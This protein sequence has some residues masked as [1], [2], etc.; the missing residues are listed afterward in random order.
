MYTRPLLFLFSPHSCKSIA[1]AKKRL[2]MKLLRRHEKTGL[3]KVN[4]DP[5]LVRRVG[6]ESIIKIKLERVQLDVSSTDMTQ[7]PKLC[8]TSMF[9]FCIS[10]CRSLFYV[11]YAFSGFTA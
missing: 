4:F 11:K 7:S 2:D 1:I 3:L 5:A 6:L 10:S 8:T 9:T